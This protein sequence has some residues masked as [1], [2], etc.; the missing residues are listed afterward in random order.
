MV[1]GS[2]YT[3]PVILTVDVEVDVDTEDGS[4]RET[5]PATLMQ[6]STPFARPDGMV[7][8][9][10]AVD[11]VALEVS[12]P[13]SSLRGTFRSK[14]A[15]DHDVVFWAVLGRTDV[16]GLVYEKDVTGGFRASWH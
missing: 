10:P 3:N 15:R 16:D 7:S 11:A 2:M 13:T 14:D 12:M 9:E 8:K 1:R 6:R 4:F 5:R